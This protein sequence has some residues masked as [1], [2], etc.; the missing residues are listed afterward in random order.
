MLW[1]E[2]GVTS[3][4]A[5]GAQAGGSGACQERGL[6]GGVKS[7][8]PPSRK[9]PRHPVLM[10]CMA[11]RWSVCPET[12]GHRSPKGAIPM[13]STHR[14]WTEGGGLEGGRRESRPPTPTLVH[15]GQRG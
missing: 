11:S 2:L 12:R 14:T 6:K 10:A 8:V 4:E 3:G 7:P 15:P 5:C 13:T 9:E 1:A